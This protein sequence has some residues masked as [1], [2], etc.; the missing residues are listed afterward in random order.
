MY[1]GDSVNLKL[2]H[3]LMIPVV[4][5]LIIIVVAISAF[6]Y[7]KNSITVSKN[8]LTEMSRYANSGKQSQLEIFRFINGQVAIEPIMEEIKRLK[9]IPEALSNSIDASQIDDVMDSIHQLELLLGGNESIRQQVAVLAESSI[10]ESIAYMPY[11]RDKLF[12]DRF[13]TSNSEIEGIVGASG[14]SEAMHQIQTLFL[15]LDNDP[16]SATRLLAYIDAT[17]DNGKAE[18]EALKNT[19]KAKSAEKLVEIGQQIRFLAVD[20]IQQ[21]Q[22][23]IMITDQVTEKF[24]AILDLIRAAESETNDDTFLT[25]ENI[26]VVMVIGL[27]IANLLSS[28]ISLVASNSVLNPIKMLRKMASG[29]SQSDGDLTRRLTVT[30]RNEIGAVSYEFNNFI[31][32]VHDIVSKVKTLSSGFSKITRDLDDT[33]KLAFNEVERQQAE[34]LNLKEAITNSSIAIGSISESANKSVSAAQKTSEQGVEGRQRVEKS[35][36]QVQNMSRMMD[37]SVNRITDL[38]KV[39]TEI[40]TILGVIGNIADQTNL[41]A[42]NAAIEA[43]RAGEQGRGFS[44]VADEVRGLA[45]KTQGSL[46][47]IQE[48]ISSLQNKTKDSVLVIDQSKEAC[49]LVL[50]QVNLAGTALE[51]MTGMIQEISDNSLQIANSVEDQYTTSENVEQMISQINKIAENSLERTRSASNIAHDM[52]E[53][54]GELVLMVDKFK[55]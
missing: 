34:I 22:D 37:E 12:Q 42:L 16:E 51:S 40:G 7:I 3:R 17:I 49:D 30:S 33:N 53:N 46:S 44:V 52:N 20:Y 32:T 15:Q 31:D 28:G 14:N 5:Q 38:D 39:S 8:T 25:F 10:L 26:M 19:Q 11:L 4:I 54:I 36:S 55:T 18:F 1:L 50:E 13:Y 48:M 24:N 47:Q 2:K 45:Q 43:A 35:I 21:K 29:L 27:A 41:L 9:N 23:L 6:F